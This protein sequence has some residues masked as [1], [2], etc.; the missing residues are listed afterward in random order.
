MNKPGTDFIEINTI[1]DSSPEKL[2]LAWTTPLMVLKWFGSDPNGKGISAE[3]D[4]RPGGGFQISFADSDH[5]EHTC[6]GTYK[7][8]EPNRLLEFSWAWKSERG[9]ESYVVVRFEPMDGNTRMIFTHSG[10]GHSSMHN[11]QQGWEATFQKLKKVLAEG[12]D[13]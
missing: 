9:V 8:V 13:N 3:I 4:P 7:K 12:I 6:F 2:W 5:T 11:Y 10:I 1:L